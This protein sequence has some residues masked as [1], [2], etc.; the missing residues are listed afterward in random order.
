M[1]RDRRAITLPGALVA[2][3]FVLVFA[4]VQAATD[5]LFD[6][7][8]GDFLRIEGI[9]STRPGRGVCAF[10]RRRTAGGGW[11]GLIPA[12]ARTSCQQ[13]PD[14]GPDRRADRAGRL[15]TLSEHRGKKA[16]LVAYA[17]W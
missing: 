2:A 15:H 5:V 3:I 12:A 17:S 13:P 14:R 11:R 4:G 1:F 9:G 6:A 8:G 16:L 10:H 7:D